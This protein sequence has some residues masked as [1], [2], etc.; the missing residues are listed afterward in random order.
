MK[1]ARMAIMLGLL[2]VTG[3]APATPGAPSSAAPTAP[4]GATG[5]SPAP[6]DPGEVVR[7]S[8]SAP[9]EEA[10]AGI[11]ACGVREYVDQIEGIGILATPGLL[12]HYVAFTG[13]EPEILVGGSAFVVRYKGTIRLP[14]RGG[15]G[16]AAST[17]ADN[18]TCAVIGGVPRWFLTG[19][20]V[21]A[22]GN[23]GE[24]EAA[25]RMDR[26]LPAPL[27]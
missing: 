19:S 13:R 10:A 20:W 8:L 22:N 23:R 16:S 11:K 17:D 24:P 4:S 15:V 9:T 5:V 14:L 7:V 25:P 2:V 18:V 21:D 1:L 26:V 6:A 3:C 27:P 12:P